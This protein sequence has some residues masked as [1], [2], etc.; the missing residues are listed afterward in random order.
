MFPLFKCECCVCFLKLDGLPAVCVDLSMLEGIV[1]FTTGSYSDD[2]TSR[3]AYLGRS[4]T[5]LLELDVLADMCRFANIWCFMSFGRRRDMRCFRPV[6][7]ILKGI[8][9][10]TTGS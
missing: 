1:D 9:G 3:W 8:V 4:C 2:G 10:F 6:N 7:M 5:C